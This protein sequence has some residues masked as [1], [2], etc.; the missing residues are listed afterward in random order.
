MF[1]IV[2]SPKDTASE[3]DSLITPFGELSI[4]GH[5]FNTASWRITTMASSVIGAATAFDNLRQLDASNPF[6]QQR[7]VQ[8]QF[9]GMS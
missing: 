2:S 4:G 7:K 9:D 8:L 5:D 3:L 1:N 6:L